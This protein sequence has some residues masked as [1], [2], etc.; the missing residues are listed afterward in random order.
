MLYCDTNVI[1]H[2]CLNLKMKQ[3]IIDDDNTREI[4]AHS[5]LI[6]CNLSRE[7]Y[8]RDYRLLQWYEIIDCYYVNVFYCEF[9]V[10]RNTSWSYVNQFNETF[11]SHLFFYL[12]ISKRHIILSPIF[13]DTVYCK[14]LSS[15]HL[16]LNGILLKALLTM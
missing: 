9:R 7:G 16:V 13:L 5:F 12:I 11:L 14:L 10:K 1:W 8:I 2:L 6:C 15:K 4:W 3:G